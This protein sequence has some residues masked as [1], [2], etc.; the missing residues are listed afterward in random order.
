MKTLFVALTLLAIPTLALAHPAGHGSGGRGF[1]GD[2]APITRVQF[3][4]RDDRRFDRD[5]RRFDRDRDR[6]RGRRFDRDDRGR[7]FFRGRWWDYGV[8]PC[9]RLLPDGAYVWVCG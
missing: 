2:H 1:T 5:D 4:D 7:R 8:G 9:W 3:R 6:D